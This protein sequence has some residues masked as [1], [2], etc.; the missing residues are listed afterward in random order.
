MME[1]V[2]E[3]HSTASQ[4]NPY[5]FTCHVG[6]DFETV[7]RSCTCMRAYYLDMAILTAAIVST[8]L[9]IVS[10]TVGWVEG[11]REHF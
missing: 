6:E 7:A 2:A 8:I 5:N 10:I 1:G 3:T 11:L 4:C 9:T